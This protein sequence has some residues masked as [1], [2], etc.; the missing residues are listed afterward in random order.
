MRYLGDGDLEYLGRLDHQVKVRGYRIELG[1]I[2]SV[3]RG[4]AG[5]EEAIVLA[6]EDVVGEKRLVAYVVGEAE[7][8]SVSALREHLSARLPGYMVPSAFVLLSSLP[9]TSNGK[10]DRKALPAP[11]QDAHR[12]TESYVAASH[13][14]RG[15]DH[16]DL[17]RG[18]GCGSGGHP[19]QFLLAWRAFSACDA[20]DLSCSQHV[21]GGVASSCAL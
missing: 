17:E 16:R 21:C 12:D 19:R 11:E 4:Y 20:G 8:L 13:S 5:V 18:V 1:E 10:I 3:L 9:L 14:D 15:G 7:T 6:R 2:E